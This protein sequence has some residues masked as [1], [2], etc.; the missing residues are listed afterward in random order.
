MYKLLSQI[1]RLKK[2]TVFKIILSFV[3]ISCFLVSGYTEKENVATVISAPPASSYIEEKVVKEKTSFFVENP[4]DMEVIGYFEIDSAA[5]KS[6]V[7]DTQVEQYIDV[8]L[9]SA[10]S[11]DINPIFLTSLM[12]WESG[13][14]E[15]ITYGNNLFGWSGGD[16][17][18]IQDSIVQISKKI[19]NYYLL[20]NGLYYHGTT[21]KDVN[22]SYNGRQEWL[23]GMSDIIQLLTLRLDNYY[24]VCYN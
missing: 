8:L 22:V 10:K 12:I 11:N 5:L 2:T 14:G 13:W 23:V 17:S 6:A 9:E 3:F 15:N 20:E 16:Y 4:S 1:T 18:D 7:K 19:K 21:L 24:N